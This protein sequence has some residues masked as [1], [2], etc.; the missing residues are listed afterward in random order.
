M[1]TITA[2]AW[3]PWRVPPRLFPIGKNRMAEKQVDVHQQEQLAQRPQNL[4]IRTKLR[5]L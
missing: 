1:V 4:G 3:T 2:A 5:R